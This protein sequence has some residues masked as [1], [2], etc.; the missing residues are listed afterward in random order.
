MTTIDTRLPATTLTESSSSSVG[1]SNVTYI[2]EPVTSSSGK[3]LEYC[4]LL[5]VTVYEGTYEVWWKA[6][7]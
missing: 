1:A 5:C 2:V 6:Q 3:L 7:K 4:T